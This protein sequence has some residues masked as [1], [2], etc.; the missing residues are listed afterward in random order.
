MQQLIKCLTNFHFRQLGSA[1]KII[2]RSDEVK[3]KCSK[4]YPHVQPAVPHLMEKDS[5]SF[6]L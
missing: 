4:G 3:D 1:L 6:S 5:P 2:Y